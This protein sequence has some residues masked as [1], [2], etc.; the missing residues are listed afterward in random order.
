MV[1]TLSDCPHLR[2]RE[3]A[4]FVVN[5]R[6]NLIGGRRI[7]GLGT[8]QK[9]GDFAGKGTGRWRPARAWE[10]GNTQRPTLNVQRP[11]ADVEDQCGFRRCDGSALNVE[12]WLFGRV[13]ARSARFP[14][15]SPGAMR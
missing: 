10:E 5:E 11:R 14:L 2:R 8:L 7:A 6:E 4:E 9:E 1:L 13:R 15:V 12:P 3:L